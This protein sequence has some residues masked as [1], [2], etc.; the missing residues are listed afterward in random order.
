MQSTANNDYRIQ[1]NQLADFPALAALRLIAGDLEEL[2]DQGF[3][4]EERRGDR[5]YY[6]LRFR[7]GGKQVVRYIG[8]VDRASIVKQELSILQMDSKIVRELKARAKIANKMIREAKQAMEPV[9]KADGF[10]F[11]GLAIRR[12]RRLKNGIMTNSKS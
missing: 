12:P 6:K 4:C 2:A 1:N 9:L 3:V 10:V 5:T 8:G 11:H 7:R